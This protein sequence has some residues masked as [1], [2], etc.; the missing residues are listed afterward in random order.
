MPTYCLSRT[1]LYASRRKR[2]EKGTAAL[3]LAMMLSDSHAEGKDVLDFWYHHCTLGNW[4]MGASQRSR[5]VYPWLRDFDWWRTRV[6]STPP[7]KAVGWNSP[8]SCN[9]RWP[10]RSLAQHEMLG[11]D[12]PWDARKRSMRSV[13]DFVFPRRVAQVLYT[14]SIPDL[15]ILS[16][17]VCLNCS[18]NW[19]YNF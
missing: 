12:Y 18:P 10:N 1:S 8:A 5:Y 15:G 3:R 7:R 19:T 9:S 13:L 6:K 4:R 11:R 16:F 14:V 17:E 2:A